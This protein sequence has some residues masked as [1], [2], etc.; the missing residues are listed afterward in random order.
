MDSNQRYGLPYC[1]RAVRDSLGP[2]RPCDRIHLVD[3]NLAVRAGRLLPYCQVG[4]GR[5]RFHDAILDLSDDG[6]SSAGPLQS[7]LG[8]NSGQSP[9]RRTS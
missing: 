9:A 8:A 6:D 5:H 3:V 2:D 1:L 4:H 7:R